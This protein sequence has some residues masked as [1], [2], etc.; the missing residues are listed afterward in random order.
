L[1]DHL[2]VLANV[3]WDDPQEQPVKLAEIVGRIANPVGMKVNALLAECGE[4]I[5]KTALTD[6]GQCIGAS[7]KLAEVL[8]QL[9]VLNGDVSL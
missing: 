3:L 8:K 2:D 6:M 1:T 9:K 5:S 4:V 7:K